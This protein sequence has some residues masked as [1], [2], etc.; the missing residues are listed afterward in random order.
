MAQNNYHKAMIALWIAF[1]GLLVSYPWHGTFWGGLVSNGCSAAMIGGLADWFAVTALFRRPLGIPPG[2]I[3]RTDIIA[4]N[5]VRIYD[6]LAGMVQDELLSPEV[7]KEKLHNY[8][9]AQ[10]LLRYLQVDGGEIELRHL[11]DQLMHD[12]L[13]KLDS[14]AAGELLDNLVRQTVGEHDFAPL[15][16]KVLDYSLAN[17]YEQKIVDYSLDELLSL[18]KSPTVNS[19]LFQLIRQA[20]QEY[21]KGRERRK[22][23]NNY[24]IDLSPLPM[25]ELAQAKLVSTLTE[26][27]LDQHH[28]LRKMLAV[29]VQQWVET[30]RESKEWQQKVNVWVAGAIRQEVNFAPL[31]RRLLADKE[32]RAGGETYVAMVKALNERMEQGVVEFKQNKQSQ[33]GLDKLIKSQLSKWIDTQQQAVGNLVRHSLEALDNAALIA[34][35]EERAGNDLQ[36]IRINGTIVGGLAGIAIYLA[37]FW[38]T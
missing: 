3:I 2:R 9:F 25:A 7:L 32:S 31:I 8:N 20:L 19:A 1:A 38:L 24:V 34:F 14:E 21:E 26:V 35:I 18:A 6:A 10:V 17:G 5:R 28:P 16:I 27:R 4:R 37:T 22:F 30:L 36:I 29:K 12:A 33:Q 23:V 15:M 11:L 13:T